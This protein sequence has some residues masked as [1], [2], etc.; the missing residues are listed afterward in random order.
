[1]NICGDGGMVGGGENRE[2][3]TLCH[4]SACVRACVCACVCVRARKNDC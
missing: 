4:R 1:M 3:L 2:R